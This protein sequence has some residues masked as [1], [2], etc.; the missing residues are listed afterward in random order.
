MHFNQATQGDVEM[1]KKIDLNALSEHPLLPLEKNKE[2]LYLLPTM[3]CG[4][5]PWY[6][7]DKDQI[8]WGCVES[9]RLHPVT[10]T[11]AAGIQDIIVKTENTCF[12]L[13]VG[14][15]FPDLDYDC[16]KK[17]H[18]KL[19]RGDMY[20]EIVT[21][22]IA[23]GFNLYVENPLNTALQETEE[24]HGID[25]KYGGKDNH[26]LNTLVELP[27]DTLTGKEGATSQSMWLASL[28]NADGVTLQY[29]DK[30]DRKIQRNLNREFYEKGCWSTLESLKT[31]LARENDK[32]TF[33]YMDKEGL[34]DKTQLIGGVILAFQR[35]IK[36][37]ETLESMIRSNLNMSQ[38]SSTSIQASFFHTSQSAP[39]HSNT[40]PDNVFAV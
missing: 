13:E 19:F 27:V 12:S 29:T 34:S 3:R 24:E 26:L 7:D 39:K 35:T 23:N 8:V 1:Q 2:G 31:A 33:L 32:F 16:M 10:I 14:K 17:F 37:L 6:L 22:M 4:I 36:T 30:I 28:K 5:L 11:P 9:N 40:S 38:S 15:S 18:G 20:Q 21:Y 25:L